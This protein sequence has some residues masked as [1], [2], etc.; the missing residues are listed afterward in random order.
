MFIIYLFY[1]FVITSIWSNWNDKEK[2]KEK[3]LEIFL[4]MIP[5][6]Y[7]FRKKISSS[8]FFVV[9]IK[10]FLVQFSKFNFFFLFHFYT[11]LYFVNITVIPFV[12]Y[13]FSYNCSIKTVLL[14]AFF[15]LSS[16][17]LKCCHNLQFESKV[18]K[19]SKF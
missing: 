9:L 17:I 16:L 2:K 8:L 12:V 15:F 13:Y 18:I 14:E 11:N 10:M 19:K 7:W 6:T 4:N 1:F 3:T 5:I